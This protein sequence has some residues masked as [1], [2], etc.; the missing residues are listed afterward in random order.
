LRH[1]QAGAGG[2]I[3]LTDGIAAML[4]SEQVLACPFRGVRYDCGSRHG[5]I[6]ATIDYALED[7]GLRDGI[8]EHMAEKLRGAGKD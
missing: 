2:E 3:Q 7:D 1:V 5:F 8:L 6:R 4:D